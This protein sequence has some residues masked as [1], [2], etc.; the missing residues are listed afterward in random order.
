MRAG[1]VNYLLFLAFF[2]SP[3]ASLHGPAQTQTTGR[4]AGSVRDQSGAFIPHAQVVVVRL[5]TGEERRTATDMAG[6]YAVAL[7]PPGGYRVSIT[8]DGFKKTLFDNVTVA[9]TETTRLDAE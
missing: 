6:N 4:I 1:S 2:L 5:T 3:P 7:L 8:A 9:I